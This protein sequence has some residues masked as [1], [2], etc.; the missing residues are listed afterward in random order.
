MQLKKDRREGRPPK[1]GAEACEGR[2]VVEC[3]INRFEDFRALAIRYERR[4]HQ[5][6]VAVHA[7]CI[8]LW[9]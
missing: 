4:G 6:L 7:A 5:F 8:T 1:F 3:N 2:R 9:L